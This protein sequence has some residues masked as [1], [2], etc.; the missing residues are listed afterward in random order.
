MFKK[1][2]PR[3]LWDYGLIY[4][5]KIL[6]LLPR[7]Q[8]GRSGEEEITGQTPDISEFLD[9]EMYDLV[10]FL[11]RAKQKTIRPTMIVCLLGGLAFRIGSVAACAIGL[12]RR[13]GRL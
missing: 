3:R 12:S 5:A 9:F 8:E 2:V 6:S 4:E 10:W 13:L 11:N 7:G 1:Q